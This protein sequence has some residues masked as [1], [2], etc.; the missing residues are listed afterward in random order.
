MKMI[1]KYIGIVC[2]GGVLII[3]VERGVKKNAYCPVTIR[4]MK[5]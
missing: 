4:N 1:L 5:I 3:G 2:I